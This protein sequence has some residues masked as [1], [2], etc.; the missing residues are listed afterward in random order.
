MDIKI[1]TRDL[2]SDFRNLWFCFACKQEA[3]SL[4]QAE[5]EPEAAARKL[6]ETAFTSGSADNITC[7]VVKFHH[8][9]LN[10][11][12]SPGDDQAGN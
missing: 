5:D 10:R 1:E 8:E 11:N 2:V 6:T 7:I 4:A 3:V 12:D 9:K